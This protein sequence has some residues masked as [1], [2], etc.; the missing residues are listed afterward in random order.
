MKKIVSIITLAF[1][2]FAVSTKAQI[3]IWGDLSLSQQEIGDGQL[4][5]WFQGHPLEL[6]SAEYSGELDLIIKISHPIMGFKATYGDNCQGWESPEMII[7]PE[8]ISVRA[9]IDQGRSYS[10]N[11]S[12]LLDPGSFKDGEIVQLKLDARF[13]DGNGSSVP[14]DVSYL[15]STP[16]PAWETPTLSVRSSTPEEE[17]FF[18]HPA[19]VVTIKS[20]WGYQDTLELES[21]TDLVNWLPYKASVVSEHWGWTWVRNLLVQG[22]QHQFFRIRK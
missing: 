22:G 21:S 12:M 13:V 17:K 7:S 3:S 20:F 11:Y 9:W 18:G 8:W 6:Y 15:V 4:T 5:S 14:V 2:A 16:L 19:M 10:F 1:I